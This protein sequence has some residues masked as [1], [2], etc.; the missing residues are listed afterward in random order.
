MV[1]HETSFSHIQSRPPIGVAAASASTRDEGKEVRIE[2]EYKQGRV[3]AAFPSGVSNPAFVMGIIGLPTTT[4][5]LSVFILY[6]YIQ[7]NSISHHKCLP[8][9]ATPQSRDSSFSAPP[10]PPSAPA[11]LD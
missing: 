10:P 9:T 6:G 3:S 2:A 4:Y 1:E 8:S 7:H 11:R 5:L